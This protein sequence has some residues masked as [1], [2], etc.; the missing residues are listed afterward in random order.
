MSTE[1][2]KIDETCYQV[3]DS[4]M[5]FHWTAEHYES[6]Y[7]LQYGEYIGCKNGLKSKKEGC[8]NNVE[9]VD[10]SVEGGSCEGAN[11]NKIVGNVSF[12]YVERVF[13]QSGDKICG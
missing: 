8:G 11:Y 5:C 4:N 6:S 3:P 13:N 7:I 10:V 9:K 2:Y 12:E 1:Y